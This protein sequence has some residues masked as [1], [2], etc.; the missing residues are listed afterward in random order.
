MDLPD[1]SRFR[2]LF[3]ASSELCMEE[4]EKKHEELDLEGEK[5]KIEAKPHPP[6]S[7]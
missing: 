3:P 1:D 7:T 5:R 2:F 6:E 4:G